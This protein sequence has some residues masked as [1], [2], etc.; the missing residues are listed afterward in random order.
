MTFADGFT[1]PRMVQ[2]VELRTFEPR[3]PAPGPQFDQNFK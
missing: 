1:T 3:D 2:E